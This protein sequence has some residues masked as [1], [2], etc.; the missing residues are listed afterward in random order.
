M[1]RVVD[2]D[3]LDVRLA[4]QPT[5]PGCS[6]HFDRSSNER[7]HRS[8]HSIKKKSRGNVAVQAYQST[9]VRKFKPLGAISREAGSFAKSWARR[10][11]EH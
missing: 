1:L 3:R 2:W 11:L 5:A 7:I 4:G 9:V 8:P 6:R 10:R